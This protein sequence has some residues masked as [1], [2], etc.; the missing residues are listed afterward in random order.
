MLAGQAGVDAAEC[1]RTWYVNTWLALV[2]N[3][4]SSKLTIIYSVSTDSK[5]EFG[6][7]CM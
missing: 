2:G 7:A 6:C 4:L 1:F 3:L 5:E